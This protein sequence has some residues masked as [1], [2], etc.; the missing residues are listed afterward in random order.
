MKLRIVNFTIGT[1]DPTVMEKPVRDVAAREGVDIEILCFNSAAAEKDPITYNRL[2]S[3]TED[4]D[5]VLVRCI[6]DPDKFS[7]MGKYCENLRRCRGFAYVHSSDHDVRFSYRDIFR[8]TDED[9][10]RLSRYVGGRGAA[11]D[12]GIAYWLLKMKGA[13]VEVPEPVE[14]RGHGIYHPGFD[15]DVSTEDYM[16]TLDPSKPSVGILITGSYWINGN[17]AH[18]DYLVSR[19]EREGYNTIPV[20]YNTGKIS[21]ESKRPMR[22]VYETYFMDGDRS[23]VDVVVSTNPFSQLVNSSQS[24]GVR[25]PDEE[26]FYHTLTDVPVLQCAMITSRFCDYE[27]SKNGGDA[28]SI[29]MQAAWTEMDG[30]IITVPVSEVVVGPRGDRANSPLEDRIENLVKT[31]RHCVEIRH[32]TAPERK[33]AIILYQYGSKGTIGSAAGLDAVESTVNILKAL[34]ENGYDTG[35]VPENGKEL[36][37]LLLEGITNDICCQSHEEIAE[38]APGLV[39]KDEYMGYYSEIPGFDRKKTEESWGQ[40][41]GELMVSRNS[42]VIPGR[43]FGKVLVTVQPVRTWEDQV[44]KLYHDPELFPTHQYLAYYR[45]LRDDYGADALIHVGTHGSLEWLPGRS[46]ALS[47][48]CCPSYIQDGL[49]NIYPYLV[50][51]PGEGIQ[52]KRRSEAVLI[53]HMCPTM[54]RAGTYDD[55]GKV[56]RPLQEYM[57]LDRKKYPEQA[58]TLLE[59]IRDACVETSINDDLGIPSD[60]STEDFAERIGNLHDYLTEVKD[61]L[62]RDGIHI[63]GRIPEGKKLD[64]NIY[65]LTRQSNGD[66]P[67]FR[68]AVAACE[69]FDL[70]ALLD[71]KGD[72]AALDDI[73][74]KV[75]ELLEGYRSLDYDT[76]E[77][78][79]LTRRSL[80]ET[81]EDVEKAVG[82]ICDTLVPNLRR[83]DDELN[84]IIHALEGGYV[85]PGPSG[86]PTR[87]GADLLPMGRNYYS[88]DPDSIPTRSAWEIG[89]KTADQFIERFVKDKG[90]YPREIGFVL[91]AT[92]TMKTNGDDVAYALWLMGIRPVW[93]PRSGQVIG[94]EPVPLSEL[95]RPRM[96]VTIRISGLFRD[97]YPN[98]IDLLDDAVK[99]ASSLEES[100]E[101]NAIAANLRRDIVEAMS[102]GMAEDEARKKASIRIFGCPPGCYG[103]GMNNA[104]DTGEW[105]TVKDLADIYVAW[106]SYA[107]GRGIQG[108]QYKEGFVRNFGRAEATVKNLPDREIDMI[109]MDDVYGY[110]G[111]LN[112][113]VKAYGREDASSYMGDTSDTRRTTVR[114]TEEELKFVFRRKVLNPKFIEGLMEHGFKGVSEIS[115]MTDYVFGWDATSD[116][117]EKWMY[118]G[119]AEKYVLDEKVSAWMKEANPYSTMDIVRRLLEAYERGMWDADEDTIERLK[120]LFLELEGS[121][122]DSS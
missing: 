99:M 4:A 118:D 107:Y 91:W 120:E 102:Q 105:K 57:K 20:F 119:I 114:G 28:T 2:C 121:I 116:I 80:S 95:G 86:A 76:D 18:I 55:L 44:E 8:G 81:N 41:M 88:I 43:M 117:V 93:S 59:E 19:I 16:R 48:K 60:I 92:D 77:C 12:E 87:G 83:M 62:V 110:L 78:I 22:A 79:D 49:L 94:L 89:R 67:S 30:Q 1:S 56:E 40:P 34:K 66:V 46:L 11:N 23:R 74:S 98:L 10:V 47:S 13:D 29:M 61:A 25:V 100:D 109:D 113:F 54:T 65:S 15:R 104:V 6:T 26:N 103:P 39:D 31:V 32:K 73:D 64:E 38:K 85:L 27:E 97:T 106:G 50:D 115:K 5:L 75:W 33:V 53:G 84:S 45:W 7:R 70:D 71:G 108:V 63:L 35:D 68:E 24:S 112:A 82:Y 96:D 36:S 14:P 9:F 72:T 37:D 21:D 90:R 51:D 101:D 17:L 69:G 58:A 122:E 3:F 42:A 111:G 52:A